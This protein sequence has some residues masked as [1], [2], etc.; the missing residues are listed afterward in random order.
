MEILKRLIQ[1]IQWIAFLPFVFGFSFWVMLLVSG[2]TVD[3]NEPEGINLITCLF[4]Y[5]LI[6][7]IRWILFKEWIF[8]PWK[9]ASTKED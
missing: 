9:K 1:V 6:I 4:S 8:L 2:N 3:I 7:L 5:P